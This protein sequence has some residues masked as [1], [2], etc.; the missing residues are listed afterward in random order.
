VLKCVGK[1]S[2]FLIRCTIF[3]LGLFF[4]CIEVWLNIFGYCYYVKKKPHL[5]KYSFI[6]FAVSQSQAVRSL[7]GP[8][9]RHW[10]EGGQLDGR[11][12]LK[13]NSGLGCSVAPPTATWKIDWFKLICV[14]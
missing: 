13:E 4:N 12:R 7:R 6:N 10:I 3:Y 9:C 11:R 5:V 14:L 1:C 2:F 8:G